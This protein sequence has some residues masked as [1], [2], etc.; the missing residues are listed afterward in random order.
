MLQDAFI[1][2]F[3]NLEQYNHSGSF[4]GWIRRIV[5]NT[6]LKNIQRGRFKNE[7]I[8]VEFIPEKSTPPLVLSQLNEEAL[9]KIINELPYGYR[10]VFNLYAIEGYSHNEIAKQLGIEAG[11]SRSQLVKARNLLKI[12]VA[13]LQK[14]SA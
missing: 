11:T 10:M 3:D 12:K 7:Q 6:A 14:A 9:L 13:E 2:I 8:G 4:E 1:K 5:I